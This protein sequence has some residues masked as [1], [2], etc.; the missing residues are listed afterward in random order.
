VERPSGSHNT[1][2]PAGISRPDNI[3]WNLNHFQTV[4]KPCYDM[5]TLMGKS[6]SQSGHKKTG[7]D[8]MNHP[9]SEKNYTKAK[10]HHPQVKDPRLFRVTL[11]LVLLAIVVMA[12]IS[13]PWW[14]LY[15]S[16]VSAV[17]TF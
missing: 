2:S 11:I 13:I 17:G 3:A 8:R 15:Q 1:L 6:L 12:S 9:A 5:M 10:Y 16:Y 7:Q 4:F 14:L